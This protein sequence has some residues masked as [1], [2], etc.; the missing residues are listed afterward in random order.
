MLLFIG[1]GNDSAGISKCVSIHLMLLFIWTTLENVSKENCFNTSH[2]TLYRIRNDSKA[3]WFLF[4]YISCYSL[5]SGAGLAGTDAIAFQYISCYSLSKSG[6]ISADLI[7]RFNTSHVTLYL[8][9]NRQRIRHFRFQYISCYSLSGWTCINAWFSTVSIH[10]MLLF[11]ESE[12]AQGITL[13]VV[14]IHLMLLFITDSPS[15]VAHNKKFQ[16]ISCYSLSVDQISSLIASMR[17]NTSHVTLY[18][19]LDIRAPRILQFQYISCYS[20]SISSALNSARSMVSIHLMLLFIPLGCYVSRR[21]LMV[22][23]HLM[24]LFIAA[25]FLIDATGLPF[26]YISCYSLS[27]VL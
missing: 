27:L 1:N 25:D 20:L 22:S 8:W 24:L 14:S 18:R 13:W 2:V 15:R 7:N 26:Q 10:L 17:F 19:A 23:I 3:N 9:R 6:Q 16:Y 5:S 11:I 12:L 4:Q 21:T